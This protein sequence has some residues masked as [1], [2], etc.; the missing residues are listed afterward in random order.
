MQKLHPI[1]QSLQE[2]ISSSASIMVFLQ[3]SQSKNMATRM[4]GHSKL[5]L[6][7]MDWW[8]AQGVCLPLTQWLLGPTPA[9]SA[10]LIGTKQWLIE[11]GWTDGWRSYATGILLASRRWPSM[12]WGFGRE[13][14]MA[15]L[16]SCMAAEPSTLLL[17]ALVA[18][19][20]HQLEINMNPL[21][22]HFVLVSGTVCLCPSPAEHFSSHM[23][24]GT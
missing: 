16:W 14:E 1:F 4:I 3:F 7:V 15:W 17:R 19:K 22:I 24:F 13:A 23:Q 11:I 12:V 8:P 18:R 2:S 9:P 10:T 20:T 5:A 6:S 21:C